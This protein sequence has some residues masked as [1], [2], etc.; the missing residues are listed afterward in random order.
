MFDRYNEFLKTFAVVYKSYSDSRINHR[1]YD[2]ARLIQEWK[3][4]NSLK[5]SFEKAILEE[6]KIFVE[7]YSKEYTNILEKYK[8]LIRSINTN[9][10]RV[11]DTFKEFTISK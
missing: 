7:K 8:N 9:E 2:N 4:A 10:K 1:A 11:F 3:S 6:V 5:L